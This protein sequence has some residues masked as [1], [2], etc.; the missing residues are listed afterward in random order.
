MKKK[1]RKIF[2]IILLIAVVV[3]VALINNRVDLNALVKENLSEIRSELFVGESENYRS[4]IASGYREEPYACDGIKN[5]LVEFCVITLRA[6][7]GSIKSASYCLKVDDK[8]YVGQF[9][10]D[11]YGSSLIVDTQKFVSSE[12]VVSLSVTVNGESEQ[13]NLI[14]KSKDFALKTDDV[15]D[16]IVKNYEKEL[17]ELVSLGKLKGEIFLKIATDNDFTFDKNYY[18]ICICDREGNC[19]DALIDVNEGS[20]V[21]TKS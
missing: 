15:V 13:I 14:N 10:Y 6:K 12:N 18:Y 4:Y 20:I 11:P 8:E 17:K 21:A 9:E 3:V 19:M 16:I 1:K 5:K 7:N 2:L